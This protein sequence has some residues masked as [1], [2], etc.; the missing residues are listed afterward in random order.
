MDSRCIGVYKKF[1]SA[2][3]IREDEIQRVIIVEE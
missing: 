1:Q 3:D 2:T